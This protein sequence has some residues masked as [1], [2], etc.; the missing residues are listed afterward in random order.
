MKSIFWA[1]IRPTST[2]DETSTENSHH[3]KTETETAISGTK[4]EQ[5]VEI[6]HDQ[7]KNLELSKNDL[8]NENRKLE[9]K[10]KRFQ[11]KLTRLTIENGA[12]EDSRIQLENE[13]LTCKSRID[14]LVTE[15]RRLEIKEKKYLNKFNLARLTT[16]N[17]A[18]ANERIELENELSN[19]KSRIDQL[20][21]D[22]RR[23]E[24]QNRKYKTDAQEKQAQLENESLTCKSCIDKL[25]TDN[26]L[27]E[28]QKKKYQTESQEKQA[29]LETYEKK[30][31]A[32][33]KCKIFD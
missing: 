23:L 21:S 10:V 24:I 5:A 9:F 32:L 27:L 12:V 3:P 14:Q 4:S 15:N 29:Q 2:E 7:I 6:I 22:N 25:E 30:N 8:K 16:E 33:M 31:N 1:N 28:I 19:C 13:L 20:K 18:A 26:R 11:E 17:E